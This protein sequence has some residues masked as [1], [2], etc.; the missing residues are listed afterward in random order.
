MY[1]SI[2]ILSTDKIR[3]P[4]LIGL[5]YNRNA[6]T[7]FVLCTIVHELPPTR[8][9]RQFPAAAGLRPA[10]AGASLTPA[11]QCLNTDLL[12]AVNISNHGN[13]D[14]VQFGTL[15]QNHALATI[16]MPTFDLLH[17]VG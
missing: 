15:E 6:L 11:P 1:K 12:H 2:T 13:L 8:Y 16:K 3:L 5:W 17:V 10:A 14:I 9:R 4:D 7:S